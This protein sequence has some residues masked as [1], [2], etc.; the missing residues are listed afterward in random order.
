M[1]SQPH[2]EKLIRN[3][4]R[5]FLI[6]SLG[7]LLT[8]FSLLAVLRPLEHL[9][10]MPQPILLVLAIP[11]A[12]FALYSAGCFWFVGTR[13][14][15]FL[16]IISGANLLYCCVTAGLLIAYYAQLT[17]LGIAYFALEIAVVCAL[18]FVEQQAIAQSVS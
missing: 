5:L 10:G 13:W 4:R 17:A 1:R 12:M 9:F 3:P 8:M 2:L 15:P 18:V 6:D 14:R 16:A 7:A 11:A